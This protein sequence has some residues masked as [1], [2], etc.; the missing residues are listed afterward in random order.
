MEIMIITGFLGTGKTTLMNHLIKDIRLQ[1]KKVAIIINEFGQRDIDASLIQSDNLPINK[2]TNGCICCSLKEDV[3]KQLHQIYLT[4]QPDI[5]L[6]ECSGV[7]HPLEVLDACLN[8]VLSPFITIKSLIGIIDLS[9]FYNIK[10]YSIDTQKLLQVQLKYCSHIIVNKIDLLEINQSLQT[11]QTIKD[12]YNKANIFCTTYGK[13]NYNDLAKTKQV[14]SEAGHDSIKHRHIFHQY[15]S[16]TYPLDI[17]SFKYW[18]KHLPP[19]IYRVKDFITFENNAQKYLIQYTNG[20]LKVEPFNLNIDN[21]LVLIGDNI[22]QEK[23]QSPHK[24]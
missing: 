19:N 24:I 4:Y 21:Y 14:F 11:I 23:V 1:H 20:N 22:D 18:I 3:T 9:Q 16:I 10:S 5:V 12:E 2:M 7:S 6:I 13:I 17:K 15:Y 8:P